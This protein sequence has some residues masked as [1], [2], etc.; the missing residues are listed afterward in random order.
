M[1]SDN[2]DKCRKF[3]GYQS[4]R[5]VILEMFTA[6]P[7]LT[8]DYRMVTAKD[9]ELFRQNDAATMKRIGRKDFL[10]DKSF[11]E[12]IRAKEPEAFRALFD[13]MKKTPMYNQ[14]LVPLGNDRLE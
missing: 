4:Y 5:T 1:T 12:H 10:L 3:P 6:K 2:I 8:D 7:E 11:F 9:L 13:T 14:A